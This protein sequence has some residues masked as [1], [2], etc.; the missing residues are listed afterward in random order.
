[1]MTNDHEMRMV[2][3]RIRAVYSDDDGEYIIVD[4]DRVYLDT[5]DDDTEDDDAE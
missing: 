3:G 5:G 1:M 4:G 2:G